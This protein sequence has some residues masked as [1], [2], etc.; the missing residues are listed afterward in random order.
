MHTMRQAQS[1]PISNLEASHC[2]L[3]MKFL[4]RKLLAGDD[5]LLN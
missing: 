5:L 3:V 4:V 1:Q 2:Q